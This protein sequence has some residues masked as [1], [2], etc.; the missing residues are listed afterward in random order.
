SPG[1]PGSGGGTNPTPTPPANPEDTRCRILQMGALDVLADACLERDGTAFVAKGGVHVNGMDLV[2]AS[3]RFDPTKLKV[4]STGPV[5]ISVGRTNP[6]KLFNGAIDWA[7]PKGNTFPLGDIDVGK[8]G[9]TV[10][11]FKFV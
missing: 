3:I 2:G 6:V 8:V 9:S 1:N 4:T 10:F 7:V 11:G 5:A